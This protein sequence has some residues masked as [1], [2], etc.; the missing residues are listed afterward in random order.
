MLIIKIIIVSPTGIWQE[1]QPHMALHRWEKLWQLRDAW[2]EAFHLLLPGPGGHSTVQVGLK[3]KHAPPPPLKTTFNS[4]RNTTSVP[5][6]SFATTFLQKCLPHG[7]MLA[8]FDHRKCQF[9]TML[10]SSTQSVF[11]HLPVLWLMISVLLFLLCI[12]VWTLYIVSYGY[13]V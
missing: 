2:D 3:S 7:F 4:A 8:S 12:D 6:C 5:L 11:L 10:H 13:V 1:V 9:I